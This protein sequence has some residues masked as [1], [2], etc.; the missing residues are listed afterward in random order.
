MNRL[1]LFKSG[2]EDIY[3]S[4][5]PSSSFFRSVYKG[6]Y[7]TYSY[8]LHEHVI[9]GTYNVNPGGDIVTTNSVIEFFF[10]K[11]AGDLIKNIYLKILLK[12]PSYTDIADKR[13]FYDYIDY[14]DF[15]IGGQ[16]IQR[17]SGEIMY[18]YI[19]LVSGQNEFEALKEN[20]Y[21]GESDYLNPPVD[22]FLYVPLPFYFHNDIS[23]CVPLCALHK[24]H[25][26]I[27]LKFRNFFQTNI[28][29]ISYVVYYINLQQ[30]EKDV[31]L[32][33]ELT[34][35]VTQ[36]QCFEKRNISKDSFTLSEKTNF[37]NPVRELF[38][39]CSPGFSNVY[40]DDY[41]RGYYVTDYSYNN[42]DDCN[43]HIENVLLELNGEEIINLHEQYLSSMVPVTKYLYPVDFLQRYGY[44]YSFAETPTNAYNTGTLN[45]SRIRD[46]TFTIKFFSTSMSGTRSFRIYAMSY[47]ILKVRNGMGGLMFI[48]NNDYEIKI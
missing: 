4:G 9:K 18:N 21:T 11:D 23:R 24:H 45:M 44:V 13:Y 47:N 31:F 42:T 28:K 27:E 30:S 8:L 19:G 7:S 41:T 26:S 15:R 37:I 43:P 14:A 29:N 33:S 12:T 25:V 32:N 20:T 39:F 34:F 3:I 38:F 35:T 6:S 16:L 46:Q 17:M 2:Q 5:N 1:E 22:R 48:S 40:Y 36:T 10:P